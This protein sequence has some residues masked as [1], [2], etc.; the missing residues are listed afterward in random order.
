[1]HRPIVSH[2]DNGGKGMKYTF[3]VLS[4]LALALGAD[5]MPPADVKLPPDAP[6][7][8]S[9]FHSMRGANQ[10]PRTR[11]H[12]GID[13]SGPNGLV[14]LAAADGIVRDVETARCWGP[15]IVIDHGLGVD[16][17][18][19]IAVYGHLGQVS[20]E[21]GQRVSRGQPI[22]TLGDNHGVYKC[23]VGI[24]HLHFQLGRIWRS[25]VKGTYWGHVRF[26]VDGRTGVDPHRYW[27]DGAGRVTCF[28]QGVDYPK[29][30]LTYPA[31]CR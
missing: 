8:I 31:S 26:L 5:A 12:Q 19:L 29:G 3:G 18:P 10:L 14:I 2:T 7:V 25:G 22:A 1:M 27:A 9:D 6:S 17:K 30:T 11:P 16:G 4:A 20:V 21:R 13:I 15:T 24:R 23:A 28:Q